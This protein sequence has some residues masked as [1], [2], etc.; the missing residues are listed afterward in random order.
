MDDRITKK[1]T[2][3]GPVKSIEWVIIALLFLHVASKL[4]Q[5]MILDLCGYFFIRLSKKFSKRFTNKS[6]ITMFYSESF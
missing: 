4:F 3:K 5:F 6:K 2:C 1:L